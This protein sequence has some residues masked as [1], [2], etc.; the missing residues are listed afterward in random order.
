MTKPSTTIREIAQTHLGQRSILA[1]ALESILDEYDYVLIDCPPNLYLA[2]QNALCASDGY[3]VTLL[4]DHFSTVGVTFLDRK[5]SELLRERW[6]A[7]QVLDSSI[8]GAMQ[9]PPFFLAFVKVNV[10]AGKMQVV[11][12]EQMSLVR[13]QQRFSDRCFEAITEDYK[14]I[15]EATTEHTPVF[16]ESPA[17]QNSQ[18]YRRMT[19]EFIRSFPDEN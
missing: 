8:S 14:D 1:N 11:A 9:E 4:P 17:S 3:L 16:I 12:R 18:N 7:Q 5:V 10:T 13:G 15:R 19:D 6:L 2:T